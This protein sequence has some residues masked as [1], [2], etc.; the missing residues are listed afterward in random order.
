M[1]ESFYIYQSHYM[2]VSG[3][4]RVVVVINAFDIFTF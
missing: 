4:F 1:Q 3:V 2:C